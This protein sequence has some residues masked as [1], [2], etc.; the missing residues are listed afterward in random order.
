[1]KL[2][3]HKVQYYETDQM[4]IVH[5]SNYIR[6]FEEARINLMDQMG[7]SYQKMEEMGII[8]PVLSVEADFLRMVRFGGN[9]LI[10]AIVTEYNSIKLAV[11]YQVIDKSTNMVHCKGVTRHCFLNEKGRPI[12][13]KKSYPRLHELFEQEYQK[14]KQ[15]EEKKQESDSSKNHSE[16]ES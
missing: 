6:W 13:L 9:V 4:G 16:A 3:R 5:H 8:S 7:I 12:S 1:M 10:R 15:L 2:Y 11:S 14:G